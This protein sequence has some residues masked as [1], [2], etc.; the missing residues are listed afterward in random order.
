MKL[1]NDEEVLITC[2]GRTVP[3]KVV[4]VSSNQVSALVSFEALLG[5]HTGMMPVTRWDLARDA[6]RS[7]INGTEITIKKLQPRGTTN[8]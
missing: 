1:E 3:G 5:G 2:D 6:Y 4:M 8:G 7:I